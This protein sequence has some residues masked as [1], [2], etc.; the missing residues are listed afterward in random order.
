MCDSDGAE[1]QNIKSE[2]PSLIYIFHPLAFIVSWHFPSISALLDD[3]AVLHA[4]ENIGRRPGI[5]QE[6]D[7]SATVLSSL[8][9]RRRAVNIF[10]QQ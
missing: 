7:E 3:I 5:L 9:A 2:R 1:D 6:G 10:A 4:A 8:G